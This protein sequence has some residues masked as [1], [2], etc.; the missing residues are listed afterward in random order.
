MEC[1]K[2][3]GLQKRHSQFS[4]TKYKW[5]TVLVFVMFA[6]YVCNGQAVWSET[7]PY[8][9][10]KSL[11]LTELPGGVLA[12]GRTHWKLGGSPYLLRDD[13]LVEREAELVIEPGVELKFAPM[14]GITVRGKL[15]A[16]GNHESKITFT[17]TE[18]PVK[19]SQLPA[20]RLVDGPSVL[21]GR[22]QILHKG[23]W[24]S[25][26]TN[27]R[28]WTINDMETACR[29]LG[30]MGGTFYN[31]MDR[32]PGRHARLLYEEPKCKGT[33][34]DIFQCDWNSRQ[35][36]SGVCDYHPDLGI[37]CLPHHDDNE[38][39]NFGQHWRGLRFENAVYERILTAANT[40]YIPTSMSILKHVVVRNAGLGR[41]NNATSALDVIGVPPV[42]EDIKI[43]NSAFN[44]INVTSSNAPIVINNCTIQNNRGYGVYVNSTYGMA[45]IENCLISENGGD[46]VKYVVH[47]LAINEKFDRSEI[48][49]LCTLASTP[50]QTFPIQ[51]SIEQSRYS[52]VERDC[53]Q[54]FYTRPDHVL[55]LSFLKLLTNT[56]NTGEIYIYDGL[57][58]DDKLLLSF[59]IRNH[60]RPQSVTSTR[61][62]MYVRFHANTRT[63]IVGFLRLTSG[64]SKTYDLN[65][66]DTII[67]DNNGRG[68][69][70]ENIRS[71]IHIHRTSISNNNHVAGLHVLNGAGDVNVTESRI[72]FNQ[73]DGVNITVTGGNR[74]IS[75][76]TV[77]SNSGYGI[78]VWINNTKETEYIPINQTTVIEYSEIFKN[79]D[80]GILHGNFCGDSWVNLTGNWF[81][82]SVESTVDIASC[83]RFNDPPKLLH[84]QIG[85]NKF[86]QN[87]R[88]PI[89]LQP[90]LNVLGKIEYNYFEHG[91]YGA[92]VIMNRIEGKYLEE[93]EILPSRFYIQHN[94]FYGNRGPFVVNL[95][96]SPY[97][98][99]Q[100]ILFSRNYLRDNKIR[101]PF[102]PLEG[103][104][105]RLT[106]RSRV[107]ATIVLASSNIDVFRNIINNPEAQYEIGSHV[108]DQSKIL[109]CTY[110]WLGFGEE[111]KVYNRLFH[112]K[113]RYNLAR[114]IYMPYLLHSSNPGATQ[115]NYNSLF[116][117]QFNIPGSFVVGG[118]VEGIEILRQGEYDVDKDINIR[119]G[120]KLVLQSGVTLKFP[121]AIGMIIAGKLEAR[122]KRPND[123][124]FT[125]KED[126]I[127]SNDSIYET[128]TEVEPTT[129]GYVEPVIPIR[130]LGGRTQYEGRLQVRLDGKWGTVC[131]YGWNIINAALVCNQL[132][133]AL[134]PSDWFLE[135]NEI[136][137]AGT[138]EDIILSNVECTEFDN[139]IT[140]CKAE[141]VEH[142]E[143]SCT[144]DNDVGLRC[145]ET[146]W[147]GLRFS[148]IAERSDMQY[149]N[150]EK[151]GL[152][153]YSSN[154]FKPA[155]QIDFSRHGLESV[156]VSNNY[157]DGLGIL[158]SDLYGADA[159]NVI[160]NS[161]FSNN[162]GSGI[163]FKQL[164][165]KIHSSI[166]EN[167]NIAGI[168]HNPHITGLQQRELA[169]WFNLDP[170]L[171]VDE[172][173]Y[174]PIMIPDYETDI[175]LVNG[176]TR[177][178][179]FN[180]HYGENIVKTY[181]IRCNPGYV[182][183]LQLLNPIHNFSTES[184]CIF[185]SQNINEASTKW[186]L[187]RDLSTF[188]TTSSS[189][190]IVLNYESGRTALG[191]VVLVVSTITAPVQNIRNRIVKG[192]VPTLQIVNSKIKGN[193]KGI[194]ALY[195]NRYLNE[196]GDH[197]LRKANET[198]KLFNCEIAHNKEEA[199]FVNTPY[200]DIHESNI[201]EITIMVNNSLITD[202]GRGIYHFARDLRSSNNLYHYVLQDN[203]IE[204]NKYGGFDVSLPYVWQYNEN[205]THSIFMY[206]NTW[207]NNQ[208][209]ELV[210]DGHFAEVNITK[211]IFT[212]NFC[213]NG[214]ITIR[215]ME[216]KMK[217][218]GNSVQRN[219]GQY[220]VQ[221]N[222]DSQS[223]IMGFVYAV[224]VYNQIKNN[225]YSSSI[226]RGALY[227]TLNPTYVIGF[228]GIQKVKVSR[229]L[230]GNNALQY[231][232][233]AGIK[234]AKIDNLLDVTENWWGSA[235]EK[236]IKTQIFDFDDWNNHAIA[237]YL[238]YLLEDSFD[239]SVSITF[240]TENSIDI[241]ALGG[242][243]NADLTLEPRSAPYIIKSDI[244]VMPE[245]TFTISPGVILEF[246][247]DV[248][249][250]VMGTLRAIGL[251]Q[252]PILMRP[253]LLNE[254][255]E[256]S[257]IEKREVGQYSSSH[258][259]HKRQLEN[260]M[261]QKSIRLCTG[262]N[263]SINDINTENTNE[264]FLEYYNKTT[265]QWVPMCDNRF[266]ERNAQ[267]VCR[268]LGFDPINVFFAHDRRVEYHSSSLSRIW[269]WPEPLQCV[270]T[271]YRYEDCPIR[272]NGQLYG[273]RHECK[274]DSDFVFIHCGERN[275]EE[276]LDYW[277]GIRFTYPEFEYSL[278]EHRIH[279]H[280]THET[281][282]KVESV[283]EN[284]H[285]MGAGILHNEKSPAVQSITK[286]PSIQ[287]I[288][289]TRCAHHGINI[290]SPTDTINLMSNS[291]NDILGEGISAISL[292]GEGRE[293]EESSFTPLKDLNLPYH[294]F[295]VI[296]IC[297]SSK[298]IT[299]EERV[300]LYYKY[301]NNPVN[302]VKIF[303]SMFRVKPFGF[304]LLQ[305]NL[306]N[307]T[308]NYGKRDSLSLYDGDIYNITAPLI[309]YLEHGSPDEKKLF[310][311]EGA[312]LSVKLF[313]N[314]ASS[315]HGFIAEVVTLPI[316]AIGLNRDVQHNISNSE[317]I[318]NRDGAITYQSVGEVNPLVAITRNEIT[319]N[320]LKLYG[321]FTTCPA[322]VR[323]DVQNTQ[324]LV[325]RNN[326]VRKNVGGLLLR[327]DSRGSATSLRGWIHN[328]LF[329]ENH[330]LSCL[331]VEGRQSSPYQ[332]VTIYRNYFTRNR[333]QYK[334]VIVLHQVV[335]NFTHNYV[336][337]NTGQRI[338]DVSGF[339][340]V[341]LPIYQ[342]TSHN[343]FYKN[344]A[345][346][347]VGR[348]TVVAG[349]AGQHYVDNIFFNPDND[350][351]MI[352][353][354]RSIFVDYNPNA[355]SALELWR[356][357]I[358]A[359]HN[360]WSY[361][362]SLAVAGRIRDRSDDPLLL[363][364]DYQ[365]Y[366][367]NN[368]TVLGGG[369][370][371]PGWDAVSGTC[372][373]YVGAPMTYEQ[374]RLFCLSDNA[375]MPYVSGNY[376]ALYEFIRRQS[377]W[378]QYGDRVWVNHIDYV[379]Q[380]T[381][382]AFSAIEITDCNQKNAFICEIDP[383]ISIDPLS[384]R[385][386]TLAV[387]F[388]GVL[389][390][391]VVLVGAA[392]ICW[393]SKSKHRHIQRLE[394]RNSIRQSLHSVRSIGSINGGFPDNTYRRKL[395][396]MSTRST[397]TL[398]KG[399]DYRKILASTTSMES[400]EKS[401]F[402]SS[403]EDNQ[404][405]DI[406]EAHNPSNVIQLKHS[407]FNKKPSPEYSVPETTRP[408]NLGYRNEGYKENSSTI[409]T[410][411]S[412]TT[413]E[414]P[415]IHHPGGLSSPDDETLSPNNDSQYFTSDT[416]PLRPLNSD[417]LTLKRDLEKEGKIYGPYGTPNYGTQPKLSFLME[418]RSKMPEQPQPGA[419]PTTTF[420]QRTDTPDQQQ[421][422]DDT[423]A[424]T[425]Q[426]QY[427][428]SQSEA[429]A[430]YDSS[431]NSS[432]TYPSDL[433]SR[434]KSEA[435][436]ETNFDFDET[437]PTPMTEDSRSYSQPLETAM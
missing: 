69:V 58:T 288:N 414:L 86:Y 38:I 247:P 369:K 354:N 166:I 428:D 407:T 279:D 101:E 347:R 95:G 284:V 194:K 40:L 2:D 239:S 398:T 3:M 92:I 212:D 102:E 207:R 390:A 76:S 70:I 241:D 429:L 291:I 331:R 135:P 282:K 311:T 359:K 302:C 163:S 420:G 105:S 389:V 228:K 17:S 251:A 178:L 125:L 402:N 21:A 19:S 254:N 122:G 242:R 42:M 267:V 218:D 22:V 9:L 61:N 79:L 281:M 396:Q 51:M 16:V 26:C 273:H 435:L 11:G 238:P 100:Y 285:I 175:S 339:D 220:M 315:V 343:G 317:F 131:N 48:F 260:L 81:N 152:L 286:N 380:C 318:K 384:W 137:S 259:K 23:Q 20:I 272:L 129:P 336:H 289:I 213:K 421:F 262:R 352:T 141:T 143:N 44:A 332:E 223:E 294:L 280:H 183:G 167:N 184:I 138:T 127:M 209:F 155:L 269:S 353:V 180:K 113:D 368:L 416:L 94:Y 309:G 204:R 91:D 415:I 245:V 377:Q 246:A 111:E 298:V 400:M 266:T 149:I 67:S 189:F 43:T 4:D 87:L 405:F 85:H 24:R 181:N 374:A 98:D 62:R 7:D 436:L 116:V 201:T 165:L 72:S 174:R 297:D 307:H 375:S 39:K 387:A 308:L 293:S 224:F 169:G 14:V 185:D 340:K 191:G 132:G 172:L 401:Q 299:V 195:Y 114:I 230:F 177:H 136:P 157:H 147:A 283:L 356:T 35:L 261:V 231:T 328:N 431:P 27:S 12:G 222:M 433:H 153:D 255:S 226:S 268:E 28:N 146:S 182:L 370:C 10:N 173:N 229:N 36:G 358:D 96:L 108:E 240:T 199:I 264:G 109:N 170:G 427:Y 217:I 379:T 88:V 432:N 360:Y 365:P 65:I 320:C 322:A 106:P 337:E 225:Y 292:T 46:G 314:G 324:T 248:G 115:I 29:Q 329:F 319:D 140:K 75:R 31:W 6:V 425:P 104:P 25:V 253:I 395:A 82:S 193:T 252:H 325:F 168:S 367:M 156:K 190:G 362:E 221:F 342:T 200:W 385:G 130:L 321:N 411:M 198:I 56:N 276:G 399:S 363:E 45:R 424:S 139:D 327:A 78:A 346:D 350:Y 300:L 133:L 372:Y 197:F 126:V 124:T 71:Q 128:D 8:L 397:D 50:S 103:I 381:S 161:E 63:D 112:R 417:P 295:S 211:N 148:V 158:Y 53:H 187:D 142:F 47:E 338:L 341:R 383:K 357:R 237:T 345:L 210:I 430:S 404:S 150:I 83:W 33:E 296:D 271:E 306:F 371:P 154:I 13:L 275:L 84:L 192:P 382:F 303:K 68:V 227:K 305:F 244:T 151:A 270:G 55:T 412:A 326:L 215:G 164:G 408:Y 90:A 60:T 410:P 426:P 49:D 159:I 37:Q 349:T 393:Y 64:L 373:M 54:K 214:L 134:N 196:L 437:T 256:V 344:Y 52:N 290:I 277:G 330:D 208:K 376:E 236:E 206:N 171:N 144:H 89:K 32:Q 312:S 57:T 265:L 110:N 388:I 278:Y 118:E 419:V 121:P 301:D 107:A 287:N 406:Y 77:S 422:Y 162:K 99:L 413:E 233:V 73:G 93:F 18:E 145:Y 310:R 313:A 361:N 418:L 232:L 335:S 97:S 216:K 235:D 257:K 258:H 364:V 5:R 160:R 274:W 403:I 202:N 74:N 386:D 59:G 249:I 243:L 334:D 348:A 333:A 176:E 409:E 179:V 392:L 117:P 80:V 34:Y 219:N 250:L 394:R 1:S 41:D 66:S 423:I 378:F 355:M 186:C 316:S 15:I 203:T 119:P 123:I 234:T 351:E 304:R 434:S 366:H 188:P 30:F 323:V 263:C 120:G 205:F 391:A